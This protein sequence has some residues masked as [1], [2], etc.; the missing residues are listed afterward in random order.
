MPDQ[1]LYF[2]DAIPTEVATHAAALRKACLE[3]PTTPAM[4]NLD[5]PSLGTYLNI[6]LAVRKPSLLNKVETA[7]KNP[8][9]PRAFVGDPVMEGAMYGAGV[10]SALLIGLLI[11][12]VLVRRWRRQPAAQ[13]SVNGSR[14]ID[15]PVG[16][17]IQAEPGGSVHSQ[18][19][20]D[21]WAELN[22]DARSPAD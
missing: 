19:M 14:A 8:P 20:A 10:A 11:L 13:P 5:T 17:V 6:C 3:W 1:K 7:D 12:A 22:M 18:A 21:L 15:L 4:P 16:L 9:F 2:T